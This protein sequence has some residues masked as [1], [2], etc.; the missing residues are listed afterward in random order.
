MHDLNP[1]GKSW[2]WGAGGITNV[3]KRCK[4]TLSLYENS[5]KDPYLFYS[6]KAL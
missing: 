2:L 1:N 4:A 6:L 3:G 5:L